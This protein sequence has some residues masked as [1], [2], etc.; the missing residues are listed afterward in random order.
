M[1]KRLQ[2]S[3]RSTTKSR[4]VGVV[5]LPTNA[6]GPCHST[7]P[8]ALITLTRSLHV[9]TLCALK[10]RDW[11]QSGQS[12]QRHGLVALGYGLAQGYGYA[13]IWSWMKVEE[14]ATLD[15]TVYQLHPKAPEFGG[16]GR[17]WS[18]E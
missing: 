8:A 3:S 16:R 10:S 12:A 15:T 4:S 1:T 6:P 9:A 18:D 13:A 2:A 11:P 7:H 17:R 5:L 14:A